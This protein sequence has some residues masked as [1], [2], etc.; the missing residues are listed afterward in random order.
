MDIVSYHNS[1]VNN[2]ILNTLLIKL[3]IKIFGISELVLRIPNI[4][5]HVLYLVFTFKLFNRYSPGHFILFFIL[6]NANPFL[7]DFFSLARGYGLAIGLMSAGLFYYSRYLEAREQ[8]YHIYSLMFIGFAT[9]AN[10][11]I[12]L[13]FMVLILTHNIFSFFIYREKVSL[14]SLWQTNRVNLIICA[15]FSA[16]LYEPIRKIIRYKLVYDGGV[17]GLWADTVRSLLYSSSYAA[18]YEAVL[19]VFFN[20][21]IFFVIAFFV[22]RAFILFLAGKLITTTQKLVLFFGILLL[23]VASATFAQN[24]I[25]GTP[26]MKGR[27][28]LFIYPLFIFTSSFLFEESWNSRWKYLSRGPAYFFTSIFFLHTSFVLNTNSY[29]EWQYDMNTKNA[30]ANLVLIKP[31]ETQHI[32]LGATWLFEPTINFY[33]KIWN[34]DWLEKTSRDGFKLENDFYYT[35]RDEIKDIPSDGAE[36]LW[37]FPETKSSFIRHN[38]RTVYLQAANGKFVFPDAD[39]NNLLLA[40]GDVASSAEVFTLVRLSRDKRHAIY[41]AGNKYVSAELAQFNEIT[42]LRNNVSSWEKF[43]MLNLD[44]NHV[45]FKAVNE[46]YLSFDERTY[47]IYAK[48][49]SI[50]QN[51]IF[52]LTKKR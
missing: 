10:F 47:R 44:S 12:L 42:A 25:L 45:A 37:Y 14:Y 22:Y 27:T 48:S 3:F 32:S 4:L 19:T 30:M 15:L 18:P 52:L 33:K 41:S 23:G 46:K 31:E 20:I 26:Y 51:E 1:D 38:K 50:G 9:L 39:Q 28:A 8:R 43:E 21:F 36:V 16:V 5:A 17:E 35:V 40:K 13:I 11:S 2:H 7:L 24:L 29:Y 34:L 6:A 49:D